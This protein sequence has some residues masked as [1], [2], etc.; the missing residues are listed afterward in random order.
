MRRTPY[1]EFS[2]FMAVA[3]HLNFTRAAKQLGIA[4]GTL[5]QTIRGLEEQLGVR[6]LNRTTRS[7]ALTEAGE[8]LL[9]RLKPVVEEYR[10]AIDSINKFRDRPAGVVRLTVPPPAARSVIAPRLAAFMALYPDIKLEISVDT[11]MVDLVSHQFDAGI[12]LAEHVDRDM[13]AVRVS[14]DV[15]SAVVG[16]RDYFGCYKRPLVPQ[17]LLDHNCIRIRLTNGMLLPWRF[18]KGNKSI[19][20]PVTGSLTLN[21][22]NLTLHAGLDGVGLLYL[23]HDYLDLALA[24]GHFVPV[25][26]DWMPKAGPFYLYYPSRR[27]TP[28]ALRAL[29]DFLRGDQKSAAHADTA[30]RQPQQSDATVSTTSD[31]ATAR[32]RAD[33][34]CPGRPGPAARPDRERRHSRAPD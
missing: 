12:R 24:E 5:S 13:I 14:G 30:G 11:A 25:L 31:R 18:Q 29:I 17:D 33:A 6:L 26:E 7:V 8:H 32:F 34:R 10:A 22:I 9:T 20:V 15:R 28:A 16:S 3:E 2:A 19:E 23:P 4:P 27:Q 21:D 1:G